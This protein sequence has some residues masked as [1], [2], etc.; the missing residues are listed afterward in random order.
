MKK[1]KKLTTIKISKNNEIVKSEVIYNENQDILSHINY[2]DFGNIETKIE[3]EFDEKG[4]CIKE[5]N[6]YDEE[7]ISETIT[8]VYNENNKILKSETEYGDGSISIKSVALNS[9]KTEQIIE[10]H[11]E[12]GV[13]ESK[14][15]NQYN[16]GLLVKQMVYDEDNKLVNETLNEFDENKNLIKRVEKNYFEK[17]EFIT[18]FEYN[19]N[20]NLVK[21]QKLTPKGIILEKLFISYDDQNRVIEQKYS[22]RIIYKYIFDDEKKTKTE[23]RYDQQGVLRLQI[24][25]DISNGEAIQFEDYMAYRVEYKYEYFE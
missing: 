12:D 4:N 6:F 20:H 10:T 2:D 5:T 15:V 13:L 14:E 23:E 22:D 11:D 18:N 7:S 9:D 21:Y 25:S 8:N 24:V 3:F 17:T 19:E 16:D 1:V